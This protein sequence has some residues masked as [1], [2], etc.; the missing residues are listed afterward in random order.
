[1][2]LF[3]FGLITYYGHF[4][5]EALLFM[6]I[7]TGYPVDIIQ[8]FRILKTGVHLCDILLAV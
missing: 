4:P 8:T 1:M 5:D 3:F 7:G 2:L 6:T